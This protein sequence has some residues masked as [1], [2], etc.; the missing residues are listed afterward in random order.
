V[1]LRVDD[2]GELAVWNGANCG[3]DAEEPSPDEV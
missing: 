1:L 2:A 3:P